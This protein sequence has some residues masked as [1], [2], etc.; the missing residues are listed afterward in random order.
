MSRIKASIDQYEA[1]QNAVSDL[2][3][4]LEVGLE[5]QDESICG[6]IQAICNRLNKELERYEFTR[7]LSGEYDDSSAL[8][9]IN[10]G[11]GGT[12]A[13]DWA[14]MMLRMYLRWCQQRGFKAEVRDQWPG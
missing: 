5:E 1:W 2:A 4:L 11:A 6:E 3:V 10:A 14:E 13:Q 7:L 12:D 8:V 9:T